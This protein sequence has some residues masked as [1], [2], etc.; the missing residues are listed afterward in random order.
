MQTLAGCRRDLRTSAPSIHLH[1]ATWSHCVRH[2]IR[3]VLLIGLGFSLL[4][5]SPAAATPG[6]T[7]MQL[8]IP[9]MAP[10]APLGDQGGDCSR[11]AGTTMVTRITFYTAQVNP[12]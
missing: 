1:R 9:C 6:F 5:P 12:L 8:D 7:S 10:A 11:Y 2:N 3:L 4:S